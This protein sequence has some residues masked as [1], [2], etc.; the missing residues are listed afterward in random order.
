MMM[1]VLAAATALAACGGGHA[2]PDGGVDARLEGFDQPDLVCPGGP[3]CASAG[4]GVLKVGVSKHVYTPQN[5]ETYTDENM[6]RQWE[7][8]EPYTDL[9]GN[10]VFDGVWLFGGARAAEGVT[11]DVEVRAMAFVEG[12]MTIVILYVDCIG[13]LAGDMDIIR[14]HPLL[15]GLDIDHIIIGAT[16]AHDAPD[17]VGL[18]G[19]TV[20]DTGR[21]PFV[22][23][24]I[25]D[26]AAMA[27]K[28]AVESAQ[29]AHMIIAKTL[30]INDPSNPASLTDNWNQDIRDPIIFD[31]TLTIARFVQAS[32]E[33]QTI[34]TLVNWADHPEVAHFDDTVP[35]GITAHYPHWLRDGIENGVKTTDSIYAQTDLEG[36]GGVTVFVQGALGGQVGSL[37]G[38]HPP[39]PGGTPI[40][41]VSSAMDQAIGTNAA[42]SALTALG[43]SGETVTNLPLSFVSASFAA[44]IDNTY[45]HV[46]FLIHLLGP[47]PLIGYDPNQPIDVGNEPW[48]PLRSTYVQIGPLGIVTVPGELHPELWVGVHTDGSWSWGWPLINHPDQPNQPDFSQAAPPPYMRDLVLAHDGVKYP[49]VAGLAED[50]VGYIVPAYNYVL[51]PDNPYI[52]EAQ[53]DHYEEVYSL[54]PKD[55][56]HVVDP[57]LQLLQYRSQ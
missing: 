25:Y 44:E 50:Y 56:E 34:G 16:H 47:H 29:P 39:G 49:V 43:Q 24:A 46:A 12:D 13:L 37:R 9:N 30:L 45:F 26:N 31:P 54:G 53:G 1:R 5:F 57:I 2:K 6:D 11:T 41:M 19:P 23:Q 10:G 33:T 17:T 55:E 3:T 18:W 21:E 35:A 38:T 36:L 20:T 7:S 15:A 40:T 52:V 27:I 14:Q 48:I 4:D 8:N 51:D 22:M 28:E 42:A 32:D